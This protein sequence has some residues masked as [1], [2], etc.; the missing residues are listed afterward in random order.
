LVKHAFSDR[1]PGV[2]ELKTNALI[3]AL[4]GILAL[5]TPV[6]AQTKDPS[7][8]E[9]LMLTD[10][11]G[12]YPLGLHM[13]L[14][15]DP[16]GKLTIEDVSSPGFD[17]RFV[18]SQV[19]APNYGFTDSAY[20]VRLRLDNETRQIDQWLLEV[21]FANMQ[22]V[23]LYTSLPGGEGFSLKQTGT[24]RPP[25][26]RDILYPRIIFDTTVPTQNQQ[27]FY[28]RF[29]N[30]ASMT[31]PL[32]LWTPEAFLNAALLDQVLHGLFF[33][34]L[35]VL[36][37]YNLFLF[38]S[39]REA[40]Y[41]YLVIN[42]VSMIFLEASYTG[43]L[44]I[45]PSLYSLGLYVLPMSFALFFASLVLFSDGFLHIKEHLPKLHVAN[46]AILGGWGV[47]VL[48]T[49]IVSYHTMT[50]LA[51]PWA[52]VS[53]VAILGGGIASLRQGYRPAR[54]F[55]ISWIG[56]F[57]TFILILLVRL[58]L[59]PSSLFSESAYRVG[60][61]WMAVFLSVALADRINLLKAETE[62]ANRDLQNSEHRLSQI[63]EGLPL[64]VVVYGKDQQPRYIN[65]R[66][67]EILDN[68][69]QGIQADVAAG[70]SLEQALS[71]FSFKIA[72]SSEEYPLETFP[73]LKALHGEPAFTDN[74]EI[75]R[76]ERRLPLEIWAS[77]VRDEA[78]NIE[79]AVAAIQ[80]I[81]QRKQAEAELV[82]YRKHLESLVEKRTAELSTINEQLNQEATERKILELSLVQRIEWL[83][84][85]NRVHQTIRGVADLPTAY[86]EMSARILELLDAKIVF[87]LRWDGQGEQSE[88]LCR[89][90]EG[91]V[92]PDIKI[93]QASFQKDSPLRRDIELGKTI[94]L[95][96]DQAASLPAPL[97]DWFQEIDSPSLILAPM[98]V[99]QPVVGVLGVAASRPLRNF[100]PWQVDLVEKMAFDLA[101]LAQDAL[102]L[103]QALALATAD[104]R[105]RLARDLHDSVTQVLFSTSLL[106][107]VLPQIWRRDPEKAFQSLDK[108][109]RLTRGAL[110][111]MR[112]MLL[113]LRPSAVVNTP[114]GEL[115]A[116]LTEAITSR[117][118]LPFQLFIE[119]TPSLPEEVQTNFYRI[120]Q[121]ALNNVVKHSQ[122]NRVTVSLSATPLNLDSAD[123]SR[124]EIRLVI[125]DDG[126]GYSSGNGHSEHLGIGIMRER[127]AAIHANL[128]IDSQPGHGTQVTLIWSDETGN[129]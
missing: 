44:E 60:V 31:L 109:R 5:F 108:L 24:F 19:D 77:P 128:S 49:P 12:K 11:Q 84:T 58:G 48:L 59:F 16:G 6:L 83:S 81:T 74:I 103:D 100:I 2:S 73:V 20:W 28:L 113:E 86:E 78:G 76:G 127:A 47:L 119:K 17:S 38:F 55:M 112:T 95:S 69:A 41:L 110:A 33:G 96:K 35:F 67:A 10:G 123:L 4:M 107:E 18:T 25:A 114:L 37:F 111:E 82:V 42:L 68:P 7:T 104:E 45:I 85:I 13:E 105:N 27:T 126:V 14:L 115:L 124:H 118:G 97:A 8:P 43:Y 34:A 70:R 1:Y 39:L 117:S 3:I 88:G 129:L 51:L 9:P 99:H 23:D 26:T 61:V 91:G 15:E 46:I 53:L 54:F 72:G 56:L 66:T 122:A 116:Q 22:Y 102:L 32:T 89:S 29:Q 30:G 57:A 65:K 125:R 94:N 80:D 75:D 52:L 63:L 92:S 121:E 21:G 40:S 79:S 71:Y 120:A 93:M 62:G 101:D 90:L 106:A 36:L 50:N 64:G 98:I 87:I